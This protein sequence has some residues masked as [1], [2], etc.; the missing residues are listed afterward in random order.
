MSMVLY[1][2]PA[3][4]ELLL[5]LALRIVTNTANRN[6]RKQQLTVSTESSCQI[7]RQI[8]P[9]KSIGNPSIGDRSIDNRGKSDMQ[10]VL[11][12]NAIIDTIVYIIL[13]GPF[14]IR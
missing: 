10:A 3:I 8:I 4:I 13:C 14:N 5:L 11:V 6:Q 12:R 2:I 9:R 7:S 1:I